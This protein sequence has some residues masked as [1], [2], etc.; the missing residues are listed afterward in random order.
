MEQVADRPRR[1]TRRD[2]PRE[3]ARTFDGGYIDLPTLELCMVW[4]LYRNGP[5]QALDWRVWLACHELQERREQAARRPRR[6]P[7]R[8]PLTPSYT[9]EEVRGLVGGGGGKVRDS[10]RRLEQAGLVKFRAERIEFAKSPDQLSPDVA[11]GPVFEMASRMPERRPHFPMPRRTLRLLCGST[12]P[13]KAAVVFGTLLRCCFL[14]RGHGWNPV[15]WVKASWIGETFAVSKRH[16]ERVRKELV[17]DDWMRMPEPENGWE[18]VKRNKHGAKCTVNL[19]FARTVRERELSTPE[20]SARSAQR[21]PE[22]SAPESEQTLSTRTKNQTPERSAPGPQSGVSRTKGGELPEPRWRNILVEDLTSIPRLMVLFDQ[23]L[24]LGQVG[25]AFMDRLNFC[26][27]AQRARAKGSLNP[28]GLFRRIVDRKLWE[29]VTN[30]DEEAVRVPLTR[31]LNGEPDKVVRSSEAPRSRPRLSEDARRVQRVLISARN[32]L[33][34]RCTDRVFAEV[35]KRK[36]NAAW[37]EERWESA[38]EEL[39]LGNDYDGCELERTPLE[40]AHAY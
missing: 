13:A 28:P 24:A 33:G 16:V 25:D 7:H 15:G 27:A 6:R 35:R 29:N 39:Q 3:G 22:M 26:A 37:T 38:L 36:G 23:V 9:R 32:R 20:M 2:T 8:E 5:L 30:D 12:A 17:R 14:K 34:I 4:T 31:F 40:L 19:Q 1:R 21:A 10:L 11:L 18:W